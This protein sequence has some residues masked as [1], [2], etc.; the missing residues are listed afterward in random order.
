ME[1]VELTSCIPF[2][3]SNEVPDVEPARINKGDYFSKVPIMEWRKWLGFLPD[4]IIKRIMEATTQYCLT[5]EEEN[6]EVPWHHYISRFPY[7]REKR[8]DDE[9]HSDTFSTT[10]ITAQG[11]NFSQICYGRSTGIV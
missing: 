3:F 11:H 10:V 6:W 2:S 9:V 4:D 7:L 5:P 8:L 1:I